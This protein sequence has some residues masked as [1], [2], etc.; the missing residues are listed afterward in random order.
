MPGNRLQYL[1]PNDW[2]LI[3]AKSVNRTFKL[4]EEIIQQGALSENIFI[5]RK[6]EASVELAGTNSRAILATLAPGDICGE[7]A[8]LEKGRATAAVVAK[9]EEVVVDEINAGELREIFEAFPRLASRFYLSV[10]LILAQ[11]LKDTSRELAREM[12]LRDRR[13]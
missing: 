4:G 11:R 13:K 9:D 10:S 8:F 1:S 2:T 7:I 5:I 12:A 6:G 3:K